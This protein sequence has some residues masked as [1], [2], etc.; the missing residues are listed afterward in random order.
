MGVFEWWR[1]SLWQGA[2]GEGMTLPLDG[3][4]RGIKI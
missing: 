1:V 2:S 4:L 3:G